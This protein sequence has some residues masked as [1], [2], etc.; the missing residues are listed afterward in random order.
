MGG[1][2]IS[3]EKHVLLNRALE[4]CGACLVR[5][6]LHE[7]SCM[8]ADEGIDA[9]GSGESFGWPSHYAGRQKS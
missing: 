9:I 7:R 2:S 6:G 4:N 5:E 3:K 1:I 8:G